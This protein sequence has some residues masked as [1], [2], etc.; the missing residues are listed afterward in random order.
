MG[1]DEMRIRVHEN[2]QVLLGAYKYIGVR[3]RFWS[4]GMHLQ[5]MREECLYL[6]RSERIY[7]EHELHGMAWYI[8]VSDLQRLQR[9]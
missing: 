6:Y 7:M 4:I 3:N 9:S 2:T 1:S 8:L 5:R